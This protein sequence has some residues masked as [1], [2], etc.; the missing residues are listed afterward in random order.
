[1]PSLPGTPGGKA[2]VCLSH[3]EQEEANQAHE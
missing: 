1:M 3:C 2:D